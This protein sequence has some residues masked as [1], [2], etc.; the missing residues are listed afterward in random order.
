MAS[1]GLKTNDIHTLGSNPQYHAQSLLVVVLHPNCIR[2][3]ISQTEDLPR[4]EVALSS[5][6]SN[7]KLQPNKLRSNTSNSFF[8]RKDGIH[9]P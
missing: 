2:S 9:R 4:Y 6:T 5:C 7:T 3:E 1:F 8:R